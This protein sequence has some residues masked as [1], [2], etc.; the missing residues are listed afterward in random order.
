MSTEDLPAAF[1]AQFSLSHACW[2]VTYPLA[3]WLGTLG[4]GVAAVVLAVVATAGTITATLLWPSPARVRS[5]R[6]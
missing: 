6:S 3:G 5:L 4:L 2:L 1:A